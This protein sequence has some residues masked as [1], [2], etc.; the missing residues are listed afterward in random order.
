MRLQESICNKNPTGNGE[1]GKVCLLSLPIPIKKV[2]QISFH[3]D[4][5]FVFFFGSRLCL[6]NKAEQSAL[7]ENTDRVREKGTGKI[8]KKSTRTGKYDV[9]GML[10]FENENKLHDV[11]AIKISLYCGVF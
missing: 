9:I 1:N 3:Y 6:F 7:E 8:S 10:L 4:F 5:L 2:G 11:T